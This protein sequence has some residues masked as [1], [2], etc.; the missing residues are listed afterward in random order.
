MTGKLNHL[1]SREKPPIAGS[2]SGSHGV[3]LNGGYL[4]ISP[5]TLLN[6]KDLVKSKEGWLKIKERG[7]GV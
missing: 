3:S 6:S 7:K 2:I 4:S 5:L 1:W